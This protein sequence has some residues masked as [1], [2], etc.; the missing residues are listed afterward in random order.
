MS[1]TKELVF[2]RPNAKN[3]LTPADLPGTDRVIAAKLL[4]V[5]LQND[6]FEDE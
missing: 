4:D 5:W 3:Y 6:Y 2:H 1:K